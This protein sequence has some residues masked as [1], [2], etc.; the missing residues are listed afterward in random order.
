MS[1]AS[2][3][4]LLGLLG[5]ALPIYL[6]LYHRKTPVRK[7]FPSLRLIRLSVEF[8]ARKRKMRNLLLLLLRVMA[9]ILVVMALSRPFIGQSASAGSSSTNP[10]AFVV[11]LDNSMSMGCTHQGISVFNTARS[12]ALEILDQMESGDKATVGFINDPGRLVYS[13]LTWDKEALKKSVANASLSMAGTNLASSLL[14]A[15]KLL[16]PLKSYRR[17]I[18]VIT[19]MTESSWQP[20]IEKYNL[21][22]V[23]KGIDLIM[24]PTG[25]PAPDNLAITDLQTDAPVVMTGRKVPIKVTLANYSGR[26][27]RTRVVIAVNSERKLDEEV[28]I[29]A[30]AVKEVK[31]MVAFT[32]PGMNHVSATVAPD[33]MAY[34]DERHLAIRV[35]EPCKILLIK[36]DVSPGQKENREDIFVKFALNPLNRSKDNNFTVESRSSSELKTLAIKNYSA[37]FLI[38]QRHFEPDLIKRLSEYLL[39]GGN[40]ITFL[41]DRVEPE[42]YNKNL[43]DDL[44]GSYLLPAR[45]FKRVGNAVSRSVGYQMTDLDAGHPAFSIFANDGNGDPGRAQIFEF[46]QV[47]PNPSAMLLCRMSHGLPGIVEERRGRGRSMLITFSADTSWSNW[48]IRPTWLPFLHQSLIALITG[49][50]LALGV[51]RPGMPVSATINAEEAAQITL[52]QPDG[53]EKKINTQTGGQ[54]LVHFTSRETEQTGYYEIRTDNNR[55][56]LTAF[57]VNP[58]PEESKLARINLR[59][60]PRFIPITNDSGKGRSVK[61]KVTRLRDG[62]D[63]S[64][65]AML[66]LL[67]LAIFES[68]F[69]NLPATKRTE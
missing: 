37:V 5:I 27:R 41:G 4:F 58:P 52:R 60:I 19:D 13:Q 15:L 63:L 12:R 40:L 43:I 16:A 61:E 30:D 21:E 46:F 65:M 50:D 9:I 57:V 7:D 67:I 24:V 18:Y 62:Y 25:G 38:N 29:E 28:E 48:P 2:P 45:I 42:W 49:N 17:A 22:G 36:P 39:G 20:F 23:D 47:R 66:A 1:F 69:A 3:W 55:K 33:A 54:G 56:I 8:V 14:P 26:A 35:F 34:D 59:R 31:F 32:N 51:I 64:G 11:M 6:H 53:G 68:W 10:A 44:G